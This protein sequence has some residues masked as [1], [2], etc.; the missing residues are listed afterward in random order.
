MTPLL[1]GH[2]LQ[3]RLHMLAESLQARPRHQSLHKICP[4]LSTHLQ[5]SLN[6]E[7]PIPQRTEPDQAT[8]TSHG[9]VNHQIRSLRAPPN[10][11][12]HHIRRELV[13]TILLEMLTHRMSHSPAMLQRPVLHHTLHHII[14]ELMTGQARL[15][16]K[17]RSHEVVGQFRWATLDEMLQY[18]ATIRVP[19]EVTSRRRGLGQEQTKCRRP[20]VLADPV[21]HM[22]AVLVVH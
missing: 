14:S 2:P 13:V 20:T 19:S 6:D 18:T 3:G 12:L 7:I 9:R 8:A 17:N 21:G 1:G 5:Q 22:V 11:S 15:I 10:H 4:L 16:L